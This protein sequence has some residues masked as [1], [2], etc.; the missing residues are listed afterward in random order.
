MNKI[1]AKIKDGRLWLQRH[2]KVGYSIVLIGII[3][4]GGVAVYAVE[5]LSAK[6]QKAPDIVLAP[7]PKPTY[8]SPLTGKVVK[9]KAATT[10]P[11]TAIMIENSP[12]ARPQSGLK[13]AEVVYEAV[14]EGGITRFLALYQQ[15]HPQLIG[16]VRSVRMYYVDWLTPYNA[17]VAHVGGSYRALQLVRN[18]SYR[19]IDQ[20]FNA[21]A[22]GEPPTAMHHTMSIRV[23]RSLMRS[24]RPKA[25]LALIRNPLSA[26]IRSLRSI[27]PLILSLST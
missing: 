17:S 5:A 2:T 15:H 3:A 25:T 16:P 1:H 4:F 26:P 27:L 13:D 10:T 7:R 23:L 9:T 11:V 8:Y 21:G 19:D 14:A 22:T 12:D 20:F 6:P 24:T 18:G